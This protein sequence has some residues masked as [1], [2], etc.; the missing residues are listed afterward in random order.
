MSED[1]GNICAHLVLDCAHLWV[2][3][4]DGI[5]KGN[6]AMLVERQ[7]IV[8]LVVNWAGDLWSMISVSG[9]SIWEGPWPHAVR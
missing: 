9:S 3:Q 8:L 1:K 2:H 7:R 6:A 5:R 4:L